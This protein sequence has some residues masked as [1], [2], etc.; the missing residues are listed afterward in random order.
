VIVALIG[1]YA[2]LAGGPAAIGAFYPLLF[3]AGFCSSA[4]R[5]ITSAYLFKVVPNAF[6]GRTSATFLLVSM[7][8]QVGVTLSVGPLVNAAGPRSGFAL[9]AGIVVAGLALL[10]VAATGLRRTPATVE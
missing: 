9:L 7:L 6:M 10:G 5:V 2:L 4:F 8:L 1:C 3:A